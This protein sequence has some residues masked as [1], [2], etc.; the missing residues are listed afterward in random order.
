MIFS[1]L[2]KLPLVDTSKK[3]YKITITVKYALFDVLRDHNVEAQVGKK[4]AP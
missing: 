2:L 4:S 3:R 1:P